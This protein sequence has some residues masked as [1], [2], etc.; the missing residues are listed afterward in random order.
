LGRRI[1]RGAS[2]VLEPLAETSETVVLRANEP[3]TTSD[4]PRTLRYRT[5]TG[6][7][8]RVAGAVCGAFDREHR[9]FSLDGAVAGALT[10]EV[11]RRALP[12]TGLPSSGGLR[13]RWLVARATELPSRSLAVAFDRASRATSSPRQR[14]AR[15]VLW[16]VGHS[17]LDVAW[18]WTYEEAARKALRTF[19]TAVRQLEG[20]DGFVFTQ[21]QPQLYAFVAERDPVFFERVR[22][23]ARTGRFDTSGAALWV[24]PDCNLP[25]GESL[26]RQLAFGMRYVEAR[27]GMLPSVA[28]LPDSFGFPSTLPTLLRHAGVDAFATTKLGWNDSTPFPNPRFEWEG[29]DGSSVLA[30]QIASIAG[31]FEGRRVR[32]ARR[33]GDLLLVGLGDG[34]GGARDDALA[35]APQSAR[36]TTLAG[37]FQDIRREAAA[38]PVVRDELYLEEHRGTLTTHHDIKARNA[39]LERAL[40][41]AELLLAWAFA[42]HATPFF[43]DEARRQLDRAWEIVLRAQFH[44]VLPG[45]AIAAVYCD[46]R[47]E[48]DEAGALIAGVTANARSVLPH[49]PASREPSFAAPREV[50]G[51]FAFENDAL[52]ALV[53]RDG[54]LAELRLSGGRN[55]VRRANR[56]TTYVDR[57]RRW[58]AWNLDRGYRRRERT[59]RV[60]G[61]GVVDDALEIRYAFGQSLAVARIA[62]GERDLFLRVD[63][64]VEWRERHRLLRVENEL[65]F[66]A[67]RA[68]FGAPHGVVERTPAPRTRAERAKFEAVGQRF[69]RVDGVTDGV[70]VLVLDTYGWSVGPRSGV[71]MLGH[72]LLRGPTWPDS[73]ADAGEHAFSLAYLPCGKLGMDA[74]ETA[75]EG[76]ATEPPVPMFVCDDAA[77]HVVATKL[78]DDGLGVIVRLRECEGRPCAAIVRIGARARSVECVDALERPLPGDAE[79]RDGALRAS[80]SP[81][82]LRSFRVRLV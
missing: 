45:S 26:L 17:H 64:A 51:G 19:A 2:F 18:L 6:A 68:R 59:V 77:A 8:L 47:K 29:P 54:T 62:L 3:L 74:L 15:E 50:R 58:D 23:L 11:E 32:R 53:R 28:W 24:E 42:L 46:V 76:F 69:A 48:F 81:F 67:T 16:C 7:L 65:A 39:A 55:L 52:A 43:L 40:A 79:L 82:Q 13:W 5:R 10:L 37:W 38:L 80:F 63:L 35:A 56:L 25:S 14:A 34:G 41:E 49:A 30:A 20:N 9:V 12:T 60:T 21:S 27:F 75:W 33:R 22:A 70:A 73:G 44:D 72:S 71:T 36:W 78:A 31:G 4:R 57:P 66:A 1:G 61:C